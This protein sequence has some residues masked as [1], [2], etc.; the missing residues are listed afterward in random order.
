MEATA[1]QPRQGLAHPLADR[2]CFAAD[3]VVAEQLGAFEHI[4]QGQQH[5]AQV[6]RR[7][8]ADPGAL[9]A[10]CVHHL[11]VALDPGQGVDVLRGLAEALVLLQ[12]AH[13]FGA[14]IFFFAGFGRRARQQQARFDLG[15]DRGHH[16][17]LGRQFELD[18]LHQ[19]DVVDVLAGDLGHR[20]VEDV[21]VLPADQVQQ[22]VERTFERVEN[23]LQRI[24]RDV[25]ILRDLQHRLPTH[26]R[27]R[28]LLLLRRA[29]ALCGVGV[30]AGRRFDGH[31][32]DESLRCIRGHH[33]GCGSGL[34]GRVRRRRPGWR[35]S[36]HG[37]A[38][39][40]AYKGRYRSGR[41]SIPARPSPRSRRLLLWWAA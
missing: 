13:Q 35:G 19:A 29:G 9:A 18:V 26:Q 37:R 17:I 2:Q 41:R 33:R 32:L 4:A 27:Q 28:H 15:Q 7:R 24:G 38:A 25:Q 30:G 14:R 22:Q 3:V 34:L 6:H 12:P 40:I 8:Q 20:D 1:L 39:H 21:E 5:F 31:R 11:G 16:Q 10:V 23:H 36:S